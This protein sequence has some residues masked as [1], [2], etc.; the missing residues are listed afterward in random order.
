MDKFRQQLNILEEEIV[1]MRE[2]LAQLRQG[3]K[4]LIA[5]VAAQVIDH[6]YQEVGKSAVKRII[7]FLGFMAVTCGLW[8]VGGKVKSWLP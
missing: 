4:D 7:Q 1:A 8:I 6:F 2:D 5:Q 3:Q